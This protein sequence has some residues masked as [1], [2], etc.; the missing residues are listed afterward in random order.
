MLPTTF[1]LLVMKSRSIYRRVGINQYVIFHEFSSQQLMCAQMLPRVKY[2][3]HHQIVLAP[4]V[5]RLSYREVKAPF[6]KQ[7]LLSRSGRALRE[8]NIVS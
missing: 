2:L 5:I 8:T 7:Q 3:D 4:A 6:P 1:V